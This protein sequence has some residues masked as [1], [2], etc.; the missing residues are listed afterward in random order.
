LVSNLEFVWDLGF[1]L[2]NLQ[3]ETGKVSDTLLRI[4]SMNT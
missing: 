1:L 3:S 2:N 4:R